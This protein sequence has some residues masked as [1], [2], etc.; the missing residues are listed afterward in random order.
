[1]GEGLKR[2]ARACGG[3]RVSARGIT[4]DYVP[5]TKNADSVIEQRKRDGW[6]HIGNTEDGEFLQF[7]KPTDQ[8]ETE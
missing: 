2:I 5:H 8:I 6:E 7:R 4:V 1:M 3:I